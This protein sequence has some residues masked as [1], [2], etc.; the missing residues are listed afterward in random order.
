MLAI[1]MSSYLEMRPGERDCVAISL[2]IIIDIQQV[3]FAGDRW[4][5]IRLG[6]HAKFASVTTA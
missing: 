6:L 2:S 1:T 3:E 5:A 4:F